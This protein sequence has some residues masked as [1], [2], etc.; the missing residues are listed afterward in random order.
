MASNVIMET[1]AEY[2]PGFPRLLWKAIHEVLGSSTHP[3]YVVYQ[4]SDE[5]R[6]D[7]QIN[8][9]P[10]GT[11]NYPLIHGRSM[12]TLDQAI[13]VAAWECLA[14]LRH[15]E[16]S[17]GA[18]RTF[19]FFPS[20]P[21][22]GA[23]F[24]DTDLQGETDPAIHGLLGYAAAMTKFSL[25]VVEELNKTRSSLARARTRQAGARDTLFHARRQAWRDGPLTPDA[26][27]SQQT[28]EIDHSQS[29]LQ[30][31]SFLPPNL[32][33]SVTEA[34][35]QV[36]HQIQ[37]PEEDRWR[38][39]QQ[40]QEW[41]FPTLAE[42]AGVVARVRRQHQAS[43]QILRGIPLVPTPEEDEDMDTALRL[44]LAPPDASGH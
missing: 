28:P 42:S 30:V 3:R 5:Y 35:S 33:A 38:S 1:T 39:S 12:P 17:M 20:R 15:L 9:C 10:W 32:D 24:L 11:R 14:R 6:V 4:S 13:Q 36:R 34:M 29:S 23:Q 40:E 16:P 2:H 37:I 7:V 31:R 41:M 22:E 26:G 43:G 8:P 27:P 18:S 19:L 25:S 44:S 21:R